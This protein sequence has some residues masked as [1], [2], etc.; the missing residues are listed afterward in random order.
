MN[1]SMLVLRAILWLYP[2]ILIYRELDLLSRQ[3]LDNLA[4]RIQLRHVPIRDDTDP[5]R[6]HVLEVHAHFFR[7]TWSES[8]TRRR[9]LEGI[10]FLVG[11]ANR[12]GERA[13]G[14]VQQ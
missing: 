13:L 11:G 7:A 14:M 4:H 6:A 10:L 1:G 9:H 5:L 3:A 2:C 8:D 12:R